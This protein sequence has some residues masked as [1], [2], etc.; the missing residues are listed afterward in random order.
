MAFSFDLIS[1]SKQLESLLAKVICCCMLL[2]TI[3]RFVIKKHE[4]EN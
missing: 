1:L 2:A 4:L 3:L